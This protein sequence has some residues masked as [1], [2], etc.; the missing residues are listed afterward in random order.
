VPEQTTP[1]PG[2]GAEAGPEIDLDLSAFLPEGVSLASD[3]GVD[4]EQPDLD[5]GEDGAAGGADAGSPEPFVEAGGDGATAGAEPQAAPADPEPAAPAPSDDEIDLELLASVEADLE[6]VD[7]A[8]A[9]LDDGTYGA[10][11][12]CRTPIDAEVLASDPVRRT[13]PSHA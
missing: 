3:D 12:V 1:E 8:L 13:C 6:A 9:A 2:D 11:V 10:C 4:A 7:A 5:A